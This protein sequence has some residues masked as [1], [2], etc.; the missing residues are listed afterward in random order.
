MRPVNTRMTIA[1]A[2]LVVLLAALTTTTVLGYLIYERTLSGLVTSRFEFIAKEFKSKL[3]AGIDLGLPLGQLEN[4]DEFLHQEMLRDDSLV[5]ISIVNT[6]GRILFDTRAEHVGKSTSNTWVQTLLKGELSTD[7]VYFGESAIGLPLFTSFGK[8]VGVLL[9]SYSGAFY[10]DKRLGVGK[11]LVLTISVVLLA[12]GLIGIVGVLIISRPLTSSLA[13]LGAGLDALR[14]QVGL[15]S[16]DAPPPPADLQHDSE[17]ERD[18]REAIGSIEQAEEF[19]S[20]RTAGG[21]PPTEAM[22]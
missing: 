4:I 15:A 14:H 3:E 21:C 19:V 12:A 7:Q 20:V 17:I 2:M 6:N 11:D 18:L 9:V 16:P 10:D 13:R 5:A 1:V 8:S 22:S